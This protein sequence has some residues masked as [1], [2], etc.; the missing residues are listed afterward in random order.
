MDAGRVSANEAGTSQPQ[1]VLVHLLAATPA[2][3]F[4]PITVGRLSVKAMGQVDRLLR[5][6]LQLP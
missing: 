2:D 6:V 5:T 4:E 3:R 1:V